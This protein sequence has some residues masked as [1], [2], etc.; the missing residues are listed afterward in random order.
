M[1]MNTK[2]KVTTD[3]ESALSQRVDDGLEPP[4]QSSEDL[5]NSLQ[6]R[7][8]MIGVV[9]SDKMQK[10]IVVMIDRRVRHSLYKKY[11]KKSRR[12][13]AH[14]ETNDA[15]IGDLVSLL[16]SRPLSREKRWVLKKVLRRAGQVV[17]VNV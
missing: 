9:V 8:T 7:R 14:D 15:K 13:K 10:T 2:K 17:E 6:K 1:A 4:S 16:E 12:F 11:V 3:Q 5:R